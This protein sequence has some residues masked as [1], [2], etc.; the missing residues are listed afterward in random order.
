MTAPTHTERLLVALSDG[1]PHSHHELY[2]LHMIVHSRVS[3]L[4]RKGHTIRA[5]REHGDYWYQLE[6]QHSLFDEVA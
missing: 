1:K 6:P 4:R 2:G 3:D 5:W